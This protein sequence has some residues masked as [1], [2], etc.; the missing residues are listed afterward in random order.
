MSVRIVNDLSAHL[1]SGSD[2][3]DKGGHS[4]C[5]EIE[6]AALRE[7]HNVATVG[8]ADVVHQRTHVLHAFEPHVRRRRRAAIGA[9]DAPIRPRPRLRGAHTSAGAARRRAAHAFVERRASGSR[10]SFVLRAGCS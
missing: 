5:G 1:C 3:D 8:E 10:R 9:R 4:R 6:R 7:Q 2:G